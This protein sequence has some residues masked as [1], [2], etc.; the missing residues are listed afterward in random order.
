MKPLT[1]TVCSYIED[2]GVE[3]ARSFSLEVSD[4]HA[5]GQL[6]TADLIDIASELDV[7]DVDALVLSACVQ[8]PSLA[9]VAPVHGTALYIDEIESQVQQTY[10]SARTSP[11]EA[12]SGGSPLRPRMPFP[13]VTRE[14]SPPFVDVCGRR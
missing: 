6:G 12:L 2:Y 4:N 5:V 9:A 11:G 14:S 10:T 7:S 3:V 8:M 13:D 1:A